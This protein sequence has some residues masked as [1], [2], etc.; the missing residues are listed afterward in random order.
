MTVAKQPPPEGLRERKKRATRTAIQ[1]AALALFVNNGYDETTT[2]EIARA[3]EVSPSTLFNYFPTKES[4]LADDYDPL[5]IH[6]LASRPPEEPMF[7]AIRRAIESGFQAVF[8]QDRDLIMAR[9]K[10]ER[11]V[12][13]LRAAAM[14]DT[15]RSAKL[16]REFLAQRYGRDRDDF[17]LKVASAIIISAMVTAMEE[18]LASDGRADVMKLV[19]RALDVAEAGPQFEARPRTGRSRVR[20]SPRR[21]R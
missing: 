15:E 7:T 5:F 2:E 16:L 20:A 10:L 19:S 12:P 17:E 13:A 4:L 3:A 6:L 18:W 14:L 11:E 1:R 21:G 8:E 9:A